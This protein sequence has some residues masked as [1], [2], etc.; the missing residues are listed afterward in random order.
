MPKSEA[1]RYCRT[2]GLLLVL[3]A[4]AYLAV[5]PLA[6]IIGNYLCCDGLNKCRKNFQ[7][8][9]LLSALGGIGEGLQ[10]QYNIKSGSVQ[11]F[12]TLPLYFILC[13]AW[14][15]FQAQQPSFSASLRPM[16]TPM[17][18]AIIKPRVQPEESPRQCRPLML[19]SRFASI[20][21]LLE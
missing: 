7:E 8:V 16:S 15:C 10:T 19:V 21:T 1:P 11:F 17:T 14:G 18:D 5:K 13:P 12:S 20:L 2:G 4:L 3:A 9:H 6:Q